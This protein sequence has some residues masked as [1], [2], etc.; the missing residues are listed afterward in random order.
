MRLFEQSILSEIQ[1]AVSLL[2]LAEEYGELERAGA[3]EYKMC[4]LWHAESKPSLFLNDRVYF[5]HGCSAQ[6]N[7]FTWVQEQ[8][9]CV[10]TFA[11]AVEY[12][13]NKANIQFKRLSYEE[14]EQIESER[15][16]F[17]RKQTLLRAAIKFYQKQL[18]QS[19]RAQRYAKQRGF[20]RELVKRFKVGYAPGGTALVGHLK[21]HYKANNSEL[22]QLK[23]T[24][25]KHRDMLV[26]RLIIPVMRYTNEHIVNL[27]GRAIDPEKEPA[28]MYTGKNTAPF[29]W[30]E[31]RKHAKVAVV[32]SIIDAINVIKMGYEAIAYF[33]TQ[34]W[35]G[36][37]KQGLEQLVKSSKV[38]EF[39]LV[40]DHDE[41]PRPQPGKTAK[42]VGPGFEEVLE[43]CH[44]LGHTG[45]R[46]SVAVLPEGYDP[47]GYAE[48][49]EPEVFTDVLKDAIA[50]LDFARKFGLDQ[51]KV[52]HSQF[53]RR[54]ID[55]MCFRSE[56]RVYIV[57]S[58][59][60]TNKGIAAQVEYHH[61]GVP[62]FNDRV[63]F[64]SADKRK[65][66]A[67]ESDPEE[68]SE[69][70]RDLMDLE[71]HLRRLI[72]EH[73]ALRRER[74]E[75]EQP[76]DP[77]ESMSESQRDE[78]LEFLRDEHLLKRIAADIE[79]IGYTGEFANKVLLYLVATSRKLPKPMSAIISSQSSSG[80]SALVGAVSRLMPPEDV[81]EL[82]RITRNALFYM[83]DD[84]LKHK[85]LS[86]AE[87]EG[88]EDAD[89]SI[90]T[91]QSE[92]KLTLVTTIKDKET[93]EIRTETKVIEGP[94]AYAETTTQSDLNNE[95][96]TRAFLM[97][98]DDSPV[99]T[100]RI[101]KLQALLWNVDALKSQPEIEEVI[102]R[103]QNAQRLLK[104]IVVVNN[105]A[106][107]LTFPHNHVRTRRDWPRFLELMAS[108]AF[109]YQYQREVK[110]EG[111][112][113]YIEVTED[114]YRRAYHIA[115][116]VFRQ[117]LD[118]IPPKA[119]ELLA[120]AR[121]MLTNTINRGATLAGF[122]D[123]EDI[124][125][126]DIPF[127]RRDLVEYTG[128]PS[129]VVNQY[130]KHLEA[131]E[132]VVVREGG[133]GKQFIYSFN[134]DPDTVDAS[135][136]GSL[137]KPDKLHEILESVRN[138]AGEDDDTEEE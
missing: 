67:R 68:K 135:D 5:C 52:S 124:T 101:Q 118:E 51:P 69:I 12:L 90:R 71:R 61:M 96:M 20:D 85:F 116:K 137:V 39:I 123:T 10:E 99:Q 31:A 122:E 131:A 26:D 57:G 32:E 47:A 138:E 60:V 45:R 93:N 1:E 91:M 53:E 112:V 66:F 82:S 117:T 126:K 100:R 95:N 2:D 56:H 23:L 76:S 73:E 50:P 37:K 88:S 44:T 104:P 28:H 49:C 54:S 89:Y 94:M 16:E 92:Q 33:G 114:D 132:M 4:C 18:A 29:N 86:I 48:E 84:G 40:P 74:E 8:E 6:G 107:K 36:L 22:R 24:N 38:D 119:R 80:K 70:E 17:Q 15:L 97:T 43:M 120:Q 75:A 109:L 129:H 19:P 106:H 79:R 108:I 102:D 98:L 125:I 62:V 14:K 77:S 103:H 7:I 130:I 11:D 27:Y 110:H 35:K 83:P 25:K 81:F 127:T 13:A 34:S 65:K 46:V 115:H 9:D 58:P 55:E 41:V 63:S 128:W 133:R 136:V 87:R 134:V 72:E 59:H 3:D 113:P 42:K 111:G 78:A 105:F 30:G 64:W 21:K 121:D